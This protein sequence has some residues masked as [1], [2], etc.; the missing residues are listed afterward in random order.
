[1]TKTIRVGNTTYQLDK[2]IG[3]GG[4]GEVYAVAGKPD[5]AAK[6]YNAALAGTREEK[7]RAMVTHALARSTELV[8]FPSD[9]VTDH[10]GRFLGFIMRLVSGYRPLHELYSPKSRR[11]HFPSADYRFVVRAAVNL[12][13]AVGKIHTT[14]C[15]IGDFNHSG[16]LVSTD[17]TVALIDADSFQFTAA[18]TSYPC[19]VGV[20]DFTPPELHGR[21]L[22]TVA[23]THAHDRFGLAVA[24]F[25]LLAMGRHPYAGR[26][27]GSE[28]GIGEAIAQNKFAFSRVRSA[29]T[30]MVP[31]P[32]TITLADLPAPLSDAFE[33]AFGLN[34]NDR[35]DASTWVSA[36]K[37]LETS[38][39]HCSRVRSHYYPSAA[40]QC[41]WCRIAEQSGV[42]MFPEPLG[43]GRTHAT[44]GPFDVEQIAAALRQ[45]SLPA[46]ETLLP[47]WAGSIDP[48]SDRLKQAKASQ[49]TNRMFGAGIFAAAIAGFYYFPALFL[50]WFPVLLWGVRM[51]WT[52]AKPRSSTFTA[53]F[54]T[55][56]TQMLQAAQAFL[57]GLGAGEL[58]KVHEQADRDLSEYRAL[59]TNLT[60]ELAKLES[61]REARQRNAYLDRFHLRHADIAGIGPAKKATLMSYGVETAADLV[62]TKIVSVPGFGDATAQRLLAW[63]SSH[64]MRFRYNPDASD[65]QA[66]QALRGKF[67]AR[68][69]DLQLRLLS[70]TSALKTGK[71][72][73]LERAKRPD[74]RL[75]SAQRELARAEHELR[76]IG[77]SVPARRPIQSFVTP[78][79]ASRPA[80]Y[81]T[82]TS[83]GAT[84]RTTH[85]RPAQTPSNSN[86]KSGV[87]CPKCGSRMIRRTARRGRNAG[88]PFWGCSRYPRCRGTRN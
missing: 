26:S 39:S 37:G 44:G 10:K 31:P 60:S 19:V 13:S 70:A 2:R 63:R 56:E 87:S 46:L 77:A 42:D 80:S 51:A 54:N 7:V 5:Q 41:S 38:L 53:A 21:S 4:E 43:A 17:A 45:F 12:A 73:L 71:P 76:E 47:Q 11:S 3:K 81:G 65:A 84:I 35:P 79:S 22:A 67:A 15:V 34:P 14:D 64:E 9:V 74:H 36:L 16:V 88:G 20:P 40:G 49:S 6:L 68:K 24:I 33:R 50:L 69:A 66:E 61:S 59:N 85:A 1:M 55:A 30:Q 48:A 25:H 58:Y 57:Q 29:Q 18:G 75:S 82:P 8:A 78:P 27:T 28:L 23:R 52:G 86:S 32:A 83:P 72:Q 62:R